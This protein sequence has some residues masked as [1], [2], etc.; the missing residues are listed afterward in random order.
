MKG[1]LIDT[2]VLCEGAKRSPEPAVTAW[3]TGTATE[4]QYVSVLTM[5]EVQRG[6]SK[7]ASATQKRRLAEWL[8]DGLLREFEG[9]ILPVDWPVAQAWAV[10]TSKS[11]A[12]GRTLPVIDALLAATALVHE[13]T[14][15][16]RN[17]R[18]FDGTGVR[19]LNPWKE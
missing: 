13:L 16:T 19:V 7:S 12:H 18:D 15:V 5:G 10:L 3:L 9:R 2:N 14:V 1:Y 11:E 4:D 6:V 8:R 17:A